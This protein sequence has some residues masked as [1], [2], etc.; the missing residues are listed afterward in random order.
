M[1][2]LKGSILQSVSEI[3]KRTQTTSKTLVSVSETLEDTK[4]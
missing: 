3:L 2:K 4:T 1:L